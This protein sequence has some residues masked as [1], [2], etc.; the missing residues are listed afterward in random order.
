MAINLPG[1]PD[2]PDCQKD[3]QKPQHQRRRDLQHSEDLTRD[4]LP[5]PEDRGVI[6]HPGLRLLKVNRVKTKDDVVY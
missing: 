2:S 1:W 3:E 6:D 4:L 5:V